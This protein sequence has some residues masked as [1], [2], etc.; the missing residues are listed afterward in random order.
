MDAALR[1]RNRGFRNAARA[2]MVYRPANT[3]RLSLMVNIVPACPNPGVWNAAR[4]GSVFILLTH[5]LQVCNQPMNNVASS[6]EGSYSFPK[7]L[8]NY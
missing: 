3:R 2:G 7:Y 8:F 1:R 6:T 5:V 4:V